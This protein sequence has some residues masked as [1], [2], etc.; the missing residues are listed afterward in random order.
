MTAPA[1]QMNFASAP[2]RGKTVGTVLV[3]IAALLALLVAGEYEDTQTELAR[4]QGKLDDTRRLAKRALPSLATEEAPSREVELELRRANVVLDQLSLAWDALFGDVEAA[5]TPDIAL[6]AIQPDA[7]NRTVVLD[8]EARNL[9][10]LLTLLARLEAT[11][12]L[13]GAHLLTH[14]IRTADPQRPM[15]FKVQAT[16]QPPR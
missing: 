3:G 2:R 13:Q 14:E 4:W 1:L 8:G 12:S 15:A 5:V 7:R 6:L 11:G 9:N 10:A 16:W